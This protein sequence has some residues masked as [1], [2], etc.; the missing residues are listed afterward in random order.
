MQLYSLTAV[1]VYECY[2]MGYRLVGTG[3]RGGAS[4][5]ALFVS[6]PRTEY[7]TARQPISGTTDVV[8]GA[9]MP[10]QVDVGGWAMSGSSTGQNYSPPTD[11]LYEVRGCALA[12]SAAT[13]HACQALRQTDPT[14]S[15]WPQY[16]AAPI[17]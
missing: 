16:R 12:A 3:G 4:P 15:E 9:F 10:A 5:P 11:G 8:V 2:F 17:E 13:H 1:T 7:S 14:A 6:T